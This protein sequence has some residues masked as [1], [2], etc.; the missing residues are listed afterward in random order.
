MSDL[1]T[2]IS[3][4]GEPAPVS[5]PEPVV[6]SPAPEVVP[7]VV[8]A[9]APPK[10]FVPHKAIAEARS[11]NRALKEQLAALKAQQDALM[12]TVGKAFAPAPPQAPDWFQDPDAALRERISPIEQALAQQREQ[13]SQLMAEEKHGREAVQ[14][15]MQAIQDEVSRN[16]AARFEVQRM[17]QSPH[18]YGALVEWHKQQSVLSEIGTDPAAYREKLR[19][20]LLAEINASGVV[21]QAGIPAA[22]PVMPS[23]FADQRNA[24]ARTGPGWAGPK[25]IQDIFAKEKPR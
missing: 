5:T 23:N 9:D 1:E 21:P 13:M 4:Q 17:M 7:Q 11:E 14:A 22:K 18:P 3:G 25:P 16:P 12:G 20:E 19:A 15:A 24:G 10:G 8:E 6:P 2:I